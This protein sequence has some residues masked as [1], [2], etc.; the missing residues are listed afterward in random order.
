MTKQTTTTPTPAADNT[1]APLSYMM[2]VGQRPYEIQIIGPANLVMDELAVHIRAGYVSCPARCPILFPVNGTMQVWC[3]L[4]S[5]GE[6]AIAAAKETNERGLRDQER[7][8]REDVEREV[9]ARLDTMKR[10]EIARQIAATKAETARRIALLE[11][12]AAATVSAL[13]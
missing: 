2:S 10:E 4:G 13:K 3:V 9:E 1:P 8:Y 12:E 11:A 7:Q 5:P 6:S